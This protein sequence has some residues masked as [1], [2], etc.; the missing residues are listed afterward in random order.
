M[1]RNSRRHSRQYKK[2]LMI[3]SLSVIMMF[4]ILLSVSGFISSAHSVKAEENSY[5]YY[6]SIT[7]MPGDTLS[8]IAD[9]YCDSHYKSTQAYVE[10]VQIVNSMEDDT[11][12]AG[13][14]LIVPY[15]SAEFK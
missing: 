8:D 12:I 6:T 5:K 1:R 11:L 7:I 4:I 2:A 10:E 3:R 9:R 14:N 15:Y 13:M